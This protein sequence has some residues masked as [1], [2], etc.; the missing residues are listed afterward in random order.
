MPISYLAFHFSDFECEYTATVDGVQFKVTNISDVDNSYTYPILDNQLGFHLVSILDLVQPEKIQIVFGTSGVTNVAHSVTRETLLKQYMDRVKTEKTLNGLEDDEDCNTYNYDNDAPYVEF[1][2]NQD[3]L[4]NQIEASVNLLRKE[5]LIKDKECP[6]TH[7]P[8]KMSCMRFSK[9][10][11]FI[12]REA[13]D[14]LVCTNKMKA[15][16]ICRAKHD[17]YEMTLF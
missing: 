1:M 6:V 9:C 4:F 16:P 3:R 8:L 5:A 15:C 12:S 17:P 7:E 2:R 13:Y 14:R 11:H 10:E